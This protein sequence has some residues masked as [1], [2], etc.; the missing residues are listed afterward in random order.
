MKRT[1][2]FGIV[3]LIS[4]MLFGQA[5]TFGSYPN[6]TV[7]AGGNTTVLPA[8][9]PVNT[10]TMVANTS[11][12]FSGILTVDPVSGLLRITDA[13]LAGVYTVTV[14]AFGPGGNFQRTL[15]LTVN[16]PNCSSGS[17]SSAGTL[18]VG[19]SAWTVSV[20][21]GDFNNDGIQDLAT[22]NFYANTVSVRLGNGLGGFSGSTN[23]AVGTYPWDVAIGD[24]NGDGNQDFIAANANSSNVSVCMGDGL[25]GF[26]AAVN[27][28]V[29]NSPREVAIGDFNG[30]GNHDLIVSSSGSNFVSVRFGDGLGNFGNLYTTPLPANGWGLKLCD[31]NGDGITD[32]AA[33][34]GGSG[35]A[36]R[37]G[38]GAGNFYVSTDVNI[39]GYALAVDVGD[40]N[41]DGHQDFVA[42]NT[43]T[44]T[45]SVRFGN[46]TGGFTTATSLTL[47][48][49][50]RAIAAADFNGDGNLDVVS[51]NTTAGTYSIRL[52]DGTGNFMTRLDVSTGSS[53]PY[54]V[55]VGDFNSDGI[56]DFF[57]PHY[58]TNNVTIWKG[59]QSEI[60]VTGNANTIADGDITPS[61]TDHTDFGSVLTCT[62]TIVRTFMFQN[63]GNTSL[64][65]G[66]GSSVSIT[67]PDSGDFTMI[68][69]PPASI[70]AGGV[71]GFQIQFN[72]SAN[73]LRSANVSITNDDCDE[74]PYTFAIQGIGNADVTPPQI[75]NLVCPS[76]S[77]ANGTAYSDGWQNGD[78]DGTGFNAWSLT[79]ST[80]NTAQA[81][82]LRGS[83]TTNGSGVDSNSDGDINSGGFALGL[84]ANTAQAAQAV[85]PFPVALA[86]NSVLTL[87]FDNGNID[88]GQI[89][90]VQLQ[91][92]NGNSLGEVRYRGGQSTY[93]IV[94]VNG[95]TPF[96]LIPVTHEGIIIAIRRIST[97]QVEITLTRKVSGVSQTLT[98][99]LFSGGGDQQIR[100]FMA[101][102]SNAGSGT[103]KVLF[104]NNFSICTPTIGCPSNITTTVT[105]SSCTAVV[106]YPSITAV[107]S[108]DGVIA[109][110]QT[111]GLPSGSAFPIGTTTNTFTATDGSGNTSTCSFDVTVQAPEIN[112]KGNN[113]NITNGDL[114]P[115]FTDH[116]DFGNV[117]E[118]TGTIVRTYTVENIG[119]ATLN[120]GAVT[121]TG[122]HASDFSLFSTT[123]GGPMPPG[124]SGTVTIRF[125]ATAVGLR[126]AMINIGNDD[127]NESPFS[128]AV[129]GTG[130][131]DVISPVF[132]S[133]PGTTTVNAISGQCHAVV[134]F[135]TPAA[136]DNCVAGLT[137]TQIAGLPS[138]SN[139]P[140]GAN[141]VTFRATDASGNFTDCTFQINVHDNTPPTATCSNITTYVDASGNATIDL[142]NL[143]IASSDN[144]ACIAF[145]E[146]DLNNDGTYDISS[147]GSVNQ[148]F[149]CPAGVRLI[150]V[151][152]TDCFGLNSVCVAQLTVLDTIRPV[153]TCQNFNAYLDATGNVNAYMPLVTGNSFNDNCNTVLVSPSAWVFNCNNIGANNVTLT[154]TDVSGNSGT[155]ISTVTVI[156]TIRP[157]ANCQNLTVHLNASGSTLINAAMVNNGSS[158]ACGIASMSVS[159]SNFTCANVGANNV[160][161]TVTDVN[162]NSSTCTSLVTVVDTVRPVANCINR[163]FMLNNTTGTLTIGGAWINNGSSDACG[164]ASMTASP[165]TFTCANVGANNV[166]LTVTD[167]NGNSSV[168]TAVVT[169]L[170]TMRP[171]VITQNITVTLSNGTATITP[172][173]INNGSSD[174]CGIASMTVSPN[175]F[176]CSNLG[177][178][179]VTL[180]VTDVNGNTQT[181]TAVVTVL[182]D[183]ATVVQINSNV[184]CFGGSNGQA[185]A[186]VTGGAAPFSYSWAPSGGTN[187][188]ATGLSA[189][190]YT[191]TVTDNGGCQASAAVVITEPATP[192][193]ISIVSQT[194]VSCNGGNNGNAT[195]NASGGTPNY[196]YSWAPTGGNAA[197]A[198]GLSAGT[199][200]C[201]VT[202][203][204]SCVMTQ[205][206]N[207][208]QPPVLTAS[209]AAQTNVSCNGGND[210]NAT[211]NASGGTSNYSYSWAPTG[212]TAA[213]ASGLTAGTYTCTVTDANSCV[214]TQT[215]NITQ[216][217]VLT[218]SAAA[219]TNVSCFGGND[220]SA[221]VNVSGGTPNYTYSWAPTGGTAAT[222]SGLTAGTYTCTVTDAN[223]CVTTQ[224]FN[225]TQPPVLTASAAAQT[226]VSCFGG[227]DGSATVNVSG[228]TPN[229]T[230]SW[231]P[232]GGTAATASGLSAGTY[233]VTVT[234]NNNCMATQTF[235]I[236]EPTE[237]IVSHAA[238]TLLCNGDTAAVTI[239]ATG[240]TPSYIGTGTF[241]EV[242]GT[243]SYTV[244]DSNG[245]LSTTNV[246]ITAPAAINVTVAT[247]NVLCN[248]DST[249]SIDLTVTGG[250]GSYTY[251][252][253][254][255]QYI[256]EDLFNIPAGTYSGILTD[257]N[258]CQDSGT[259]VIN[260]PLPLQISS[261]TIN[262]SGCTIDDGS[263]NT[264]ISGGT[265]GY[266]YLWSTGDTTA[267]VSS[268]ADGTYSLTVTDTNSC[269]ITSSFTLTDPAPPAVTY[270][271]ANDTVCQSTTTSF[272]LTGGSP[273]G[274]LYSGSGV[275]NDTMFDPMA[276]IIGYNVITYTYTDT[277]GCSASAI[278]SIYVDLC[279][280][281]SAA[282][283]ELQVLIYPNPNNGNFTIQTTSYAD[284]L[285]FDAQGKLVRTEK[286]QS[287][288]GHQITIEAS[289]MYLITVIDNQGRRNT[290]RVLVNK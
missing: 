132:T 98:S 45:A 207:I 133:C 31:F 289:G 216:P 86:L 162:G 43:T 271:A 240:G 120:T 46:G 116:T 256:T 16:D 188:I 148:T 123:L 77:N 282:T 154:A 66:G 205:T 87:E 11:A 125:D 152:V 139:F 231:A 106:N 214:T 222:A 268:L 26:S 90:G 166:T 13:Q 286:V 68:G 78:N 228:G 73:G 6:V 247:T 218:A 27:Y 47:G 181:G 259:I 67:G 275:V 199:Y 28:V 135:A 248:G 232:T 39:A 50:P 126:S 91:N 269:V 267:T 48:T 18:V 103:D 237:L 175:T 186:I 22:A 35:V 258:G 71:G 253:N 227:N 266:T 264:T 121:I 235:T 69:L 97:G 184:N 174:A 4:A 229:Y 56:D 230:Y 102:N 20:D 246:T 196:S 57:I 149:S 276:A 70:A 197:T 165:S 160:T 242:A 208:T 92:V 36:V 129:Q 285:I 55:A 265:P 255:G 172:A 179:T 223:S 170:D 130:N 140:V 209:V 115:S 180:T 12:S 40:F 88:N 117:L 290:Q 76:T 82:F 201:T 5:P 63:T 270:T 143:G 34:I 112:V 29:T 150:P 280:G 168:C 146:Y 25:G 96:T 288:I 250:T 95:I 219:Q 60:N 101:F 30:D 151:R 167:V 183:L 53:Q 278:D 108:C 42:T 33:T 234:D 17:F 233:T 156:D 142:L 244:T 225:I 173:M 191:C 51:A 182:S 171:N 284:V 72:P 134:N 80:G 21:V 128:F 81:G 124:G 213:T 203:A 107:D 59:G 217:P 144:C 272:V 54:D 192:V 131:A 279:L 83:S 79:A 104:V 41:N 145:R 187:A 260:E 263:I 100:K 23:I 194:N 198:S 195:V 127:C 49:Y 161:L 2:V 252:W 204:N 176:N 239:T 241:Y 178:N 211:V 245:C 94:D 249:G 287:H 220:G 189:G 118:C 221:T 137:V 200:T 257:A 37:L 185:T 75:Y 44:N 15:T 1:L 8:S 238:S 62:G 89:V 113:T 99:T 10:T 251:D 9:A 243:Y 141:T 7:Q 224:T 158:D 254:N 157:V 153:A 24:L 169:I 202:D 226:N 84:Y 274:G 215:F 262:P 110:V 111:T 261:N 105:P 281:I 85:R 273:F 14:V 147:P 122:T 212:G 119:N 93:E 3:L 283:E 177:A 193:S 159:P 109:V 74:N 277:S 236:A 136:T 138:G 58:S 64:W 65:L 61:L 206:F 155:C 190:V 32:F 210:G 163:T 38:D 114:T 52:G 19:A 164:I